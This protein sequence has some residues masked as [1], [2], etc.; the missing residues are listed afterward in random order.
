[1][2][3][4]NA[5]TLKI[6]E[7][8]GKRPPYAILS[9]TWGNHEVSFQ[10]FLSSPALRQADTSFTTGDG[11]GAGYAKIRATCAQARKQGLDYVWIDTC[12][13]D[14]TS[15]AELGE[16]INSMFLWYRDAAICFAF[17]EDVD[18]GH[19]TPASSLSGVPGAFGAM[20][21][22]HSR[23]FTRG[24]TLQ[25]LIAPRNLEFYNKHW[26]KIGE[27]SS[28]AEPLHNITG[29]DEFVLKGGPLEQ[30]SVGRR[31][32]W[33]SDRQTTREEDLAYSLLGIFNVNM[34]LIYGEGR[35][36]FQ[37][38]QEQILR[39]SD[40]H[41]LFAWQSSTTDHDQN[42]ATGL[43][44]QSPNDF[45]KFRD[46][47]DG[48]GAFQRWEGV[49]LIPIDQ[50]V[51]VWD[52][53]APQRPIT[54]TN[55]GIQITSRVFDFSAPLRRELM[56]LVLNCSPGGNPFLLTG[57]Y[58]RRQREDCYARV[59]PDLLVDVEIGN[60][61]FETCTIHGLRT[62]E[63]VQA[64][65]YYEPWTTMPWILQEM[66]YE[67][68][69]DVQKRYEHAIYMDKSSI[70]KWTVFGGYSLRAMFVG[71]GSGQFRYF[72]FDAED[73]T[74]MVLKHFPGFEVILVM[75]SINNPSDLLLILLTS[76]VS[77]QNAPTLRLTAVSNQQQTLGTNLERIP[78][79]ISM[80]DNMPLRQTQTV[81]LPNRLLRV[82]VY[83][84]PIF[85]GK[86]PM[87]AVRL[88]GPWPVSMRSWLRLISHVA[89]FMSVFLPPVG[90]LCCLGA[91]DRGSLF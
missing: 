69:Y 89:M 7:F 14:K 8:F 63:D 10:D 15:S 35:R 9:H 48:T 16:A 76:E 81:E 65:H 39:Q 21:L 85:V 74:D 38:L 51:R 88:S 71:N 72:Q 54:L 70:R 6:Q 86:I 66:S 68:V 29:V 32:S 17:L 73:H 44:A 40:D 49:S 50:I 78:S 22:G 42:R 5:H 4:I 75:R 43:L 56:I 34:P 87:Q 91:I 33:A 52:T 90:L 80:M 46:S 82:S 18:V 28:L 41:T 83:I 36:A 37:R 26:T 11:R 19:T 79:L 62:A 20:G 67:Y 2:R 31:M 60:R 25:E 61:Q 27:K 12:C 1:M 55:K 53:K 59:R 84:E 57:I 3:L 24:W 30:V 58:V 47:V 45:R 23:W 64:H 77:E 13:I